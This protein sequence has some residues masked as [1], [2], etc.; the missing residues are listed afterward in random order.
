MTEITN[1]KLD[2]KLKKL[3]SMESDE[4]IAVKITVAQAKELLESGQGEVAYNKIL[5]KILDSRAELE[6]AVQE[7]FK[8]SEIQSFKK[9]IA[10]HMQKVTEYIDRIESASIDFVDVE[11]DK[12]IETSKEYE[13]QIYELVATEENYKNLLK[14]YNDLKNEVKVYISDKNSLESEK[15]KLL[16]EL[17]KITKELEGAKTTSS[18][19]IEKINE[20]LTKAIETDDNY[21]KK[22]EEIEKA[23]DD[24]KAEKN[25]LTV[26]KE[27]QALTISS[28]EEQI[29]LKDGII[30]NQENLYKELQ[31]VNKD[32][33]KNK[34]YIDT[35][36]NERINSLERQIDKLENRNTGLEEKLSNEK[37]SNKNLEKQKN[38]L[39]EKKETLEKENTELKKELSNEKNT[40]KNLEEQK[41]ILKGKKETLENKNTELKEELDKEKESNKNLEKQITTLG[42]ENKRLE[43]ALNEKEELNK[44]LEEQITQLKEKISELEKDIVEDE[45]NSN[46]EK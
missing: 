35:N 41:N 13:Q 39:K 28:L 5:Q 16:C 22:I 45:N 18:Q 34:D 14:E 33:A 23:R 12:Y 15:D 24:F 20:L 37:E 27:E 6:K 9:N 10:F 29:K 11:T 32:L 36:F 19:Q 25:D 38:I 43:D 40:N 7:Q 46:I 3:E 21:R 42:I 44:S 8:T 2:V 30:A 17:E 1:S 31:N 4:Q 26:E